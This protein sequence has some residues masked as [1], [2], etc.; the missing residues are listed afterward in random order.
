M[1]T[2]K[3]KIQ[4]DLDRERMARIRGE[5]PSLPESAETIAPISRQDAETL[6]ALGFPV[7]ADTPIKD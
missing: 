7:S 5:D 1:S 2:R 4:F 3:K 6:K